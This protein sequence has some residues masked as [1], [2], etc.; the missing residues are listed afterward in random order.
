[1][2]FSK[3]RKQSTRYSTGGS[4]S[5]AYR[6]CAC[7]KDACFIVQH[8]PVPSKHRYTH[9]PTRV[10]TA[11]L[12][13][14]LGVACDARTSIPLHSGIGMEWSCETDVC[15]SACLVAAVRNTAYLHSCACLHRQLLHLATDAA[16][17]FVWHVP[18]REQ[19]RPSPQARPCQR[20][21]ESVA[22]LF[23]TYTPVR[24]TNSRSRTANLQLLLNGSDTD[25]A[26]LLSE[27]GWRCAV[28]ARHSLLF[29]RFWSF[30]L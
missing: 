4:T 5:S 9:G 15:L 28:R 27:W 25:G 22:V 24:V 16:T 21:V 1:M 14:N 19:Q 20:Q 10:T 29:F 7:C 23:S 30:F 17:C 11:V 13:N 3:D 12:A 6:T 2:L 26:S 18:K 8:Y